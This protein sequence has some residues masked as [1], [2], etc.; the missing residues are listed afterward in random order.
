[1]VLTMSKEQSLNDDYIDI[2]Y[3]ELT[4]PIKMIID[5]CNHDSQ[6][7]VGE[8]NE[9][10]YPIDV[11]DILYIEWVDGRSCICTAD[12]VYTT[13]QTISQLEQYLAGKGFIRAS[14]P[15]IVNIYKVKWISG[16]MNMKLTAELT[17][18]EK[19]AVSRHYRNNILNRIYEM[20]REGR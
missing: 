7:I 6:T 12:N 2:K 9:K 20:G 10:K 16:M 14:K 19:I 1:M 18:G 5:I 11:N 15:M 3:R 8:I 17:N 4:S 13:T